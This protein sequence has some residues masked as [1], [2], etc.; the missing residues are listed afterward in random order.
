[1]VF[2][3]SSKVGL[4]EKVGRCLTTANGAIYN[5]NLHPV[6]TY[7]HCIKRIV[8]LCRCFLYALWLCAIVC[9]CVVLVFWHL[10][11]L[12]FVSSCVTNCHLFPLAS[13]V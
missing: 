4:P 7:T 1:L 11:V 9:V 12:W 6:Y 13:S 3:S 2:I 5:T 10:C 8:F